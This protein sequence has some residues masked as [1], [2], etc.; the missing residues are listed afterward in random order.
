MNGLISEGTPIVNRRK[1]IAA[2]G[3]TAV[4][5]WTAGCISVSGGTKDLV[6]E[7]CT[8]DKKDASIQIA[9]TDSGDTTFEETV[10][11]PSESCGDLVDGVERED[12]FSDAGTYTVDI[13]VE[14]YDAAEEQIE[15]S[16]Q[17]IDDNSDTVGITIDESEIGIG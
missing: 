6:V 13:S 2:A 9:Q 12:I 16:K 10:A 8:D 15:V 17:E 11:V 1:F 3:V 7:N 5:S 14:G 4:G